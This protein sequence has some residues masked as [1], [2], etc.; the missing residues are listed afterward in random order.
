MI[1][2]SNERETFYLK[3]TGWKRPY[4]RNSQQSIYFIIVI[5]TSVI[6]LCEQLSILV[7]AWW[8]DRE[9]KNHLASFTVHS[10]MVCVRWCILEAKGTVPLP[11][12]LFI[13]QYIDGNTDK[14]KSSVYSRGKGNCPPWHC[15]LCITPMETPTVCVRRCIQEAKRIV[16]LLLALF[17]VNNI[18][19]NTIQ[20]TN[21]SCLSMYSRGK[22]N[23][24]PSHVSDV[25]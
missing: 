8:I 3:G 22:G 11:Q 19:G 4:W 16:P 15:S 21:G 14:H 12:T 25:N 23:C 10:P 24:S 18:K 5:W 20:N 6:V 7:F 9:Y 1:E 2:L 17:I 13:V